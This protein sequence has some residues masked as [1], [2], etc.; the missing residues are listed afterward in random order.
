M[1]YEI[2]TGKEIRRD[3]KYPFDK[4]EVGESFLIPVDDI[5]SR[6]ERLSIQ[7]PLLNA[8]KRQ[9]YIVTTRTRKNEGGIRV[10]LQGKLKK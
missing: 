5:K 2:E 3:S 4:M 9:G 1:K 6:E 7:S 8:A 10:W